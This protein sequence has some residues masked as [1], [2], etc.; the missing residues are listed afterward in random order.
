M[1]AQ[2]RTLPRTF[3]SLAVEYTLLRRPSEVRAALAAEAG[4]I[5]GSGGDDDE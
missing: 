5:T 4:G 3:L 1:L 2:L